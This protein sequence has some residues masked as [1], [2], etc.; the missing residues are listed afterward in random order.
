MEAW[1]RMCDELTDG[2]LET[3]TEAER[4]WP[5]EYD[6]SGRMDGQCTGADA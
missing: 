6:G 4:N 1:H 5:L 2:D 3:K